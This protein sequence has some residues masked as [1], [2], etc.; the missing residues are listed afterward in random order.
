M[1]KHK[2]VRKEDTS[3]VCLEVCGSV[4]VVENLVDFN[5]L[6]YTRGDAAFDLIT[7]ASTFSIPQCISPAPLSPSSCLSAYPF[8]F[9]SLY[10]YVISIPHI[11]L[12]I[13][14]LSSVSLPS[15]Y[16][17]FL[18]TASAYDRLTIFNIFFMGLF[19]K[20]TSVLLK[21]LQSFCVCEC[22][23]VGATR[24]SGCQ[25]DWTLL[26]GLDASDLVVLSQA[27]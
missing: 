10:F 13:C 11:L 27:D 14:Y 20:M 1:M 16:L 18:F 8:A 2:S 21:G 24:I 23:C 26:Y 25:P 7:D 5:P 19:F 12:Y 6:H 15:S 9:V 3:W 17:P 4:I 22:R